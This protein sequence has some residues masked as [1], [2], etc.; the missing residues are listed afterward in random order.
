[1]LVVVGLILKL[2]N[3]DETFK[4]ELNQPIVARLNNQKN[5]NTM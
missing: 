1:L 4:I 5:Q 3:S 2:K